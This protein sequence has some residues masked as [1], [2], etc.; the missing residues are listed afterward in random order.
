MTPYQVIDDQWIKLTEG[1]YSGIVY[2]YGRVSLLEED[3]HLKVQFE[4]EL[5]DGSR[6]DDNFTQHIG[7]ILTELIEE[8]LM[9]N[10]LVYT[11]GI[12]ADRAENSSKLNSQ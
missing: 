8:G 6:L 12:D 9:K 3:D 1:P 11:G 2:K 7:P 5:K 4:Y 10:S